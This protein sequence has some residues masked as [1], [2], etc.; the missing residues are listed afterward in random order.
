MRLVHGA[1]RQLRLWQTDL[2]SLER[3]VVFVGNP[4][5]GTSLMMNMLE[6]AGLPVLTDG[7]RIADDDNPKGYFE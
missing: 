7:E 3:F 6:A 2:S 4:R 5:S 1:Q